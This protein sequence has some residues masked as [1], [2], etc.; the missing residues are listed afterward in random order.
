ML[1]ELEIPNLLQLTEQSTS[2]D[3]S[4]LLN[5]YLIILQGQQKRL[6]FNSNASKIYIMQNLFN[7]TSILVEEE[8][9]TINIYTITFINNGVLYIYRI[10]HNVEDNLFSIIISKSSES[11]TQENDLLNLV[12]NSLSI[13]ST[14]TIKDAEINLWIASAKLDLVRLG[15]IV[16]NP[17]NEMIK[18]A[19][20]L[21][22]KGH[23]GNVDIKEK[24]LALR[25]YDNIVKSLY[26]TKEYIGE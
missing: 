6:I 9:K 8:E 1:E 15:I 4:S 18:A 21:Y 17:L 16:E 25:T 26:L 12:K 22:V 23:F 3:I 2:S 14:S 19:I 10:E 13:V 20:V 5:D 7:T 24:E 11:I